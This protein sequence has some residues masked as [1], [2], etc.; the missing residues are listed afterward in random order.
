MASSSESYKLL[1]IYRY[2]INTALVTSTLFYINGGGDCCIFII[3]LSK[4]VAVLYGHNKG[5][6][7]HSIHSFHTNLAACSKHSNAFILLYIIS[8]I[9]LPPCL[10]LFKTIHDD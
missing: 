6:Q 2:L 3:S 8:Y 1:Q 7:M 10:Q 4:I 5:S 9:Y